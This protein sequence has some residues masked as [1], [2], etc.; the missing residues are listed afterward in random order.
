MTEHHITCADCDELLSGYFED[1]L[2]APARAS[3]EAH[4]AGCARCQRLIRDIDGIR[5]DAAALPGMVP[6]R[7][8]WQ[9]IESRIQPTVVPILL[10]RQ[11]GLSRR[12]LG[13]AAAGLIVISSSI[14][15]VATRS[16]NGTSKRPVR[17][18]Q[19]PPEVPAGTTDENGSL[20][21]GVVTQ[22]AGA[23]PARNPE[24]ARTE[25]RPAGRSTTSGRTALASAASAASPSE[26]ALA[27]EISR[28]Q[29]LLRERRS[30]L[31][32]STVKV[33][34][35][36]L[37]LIDAA[38]MQARSALERDP[39]SGFLT[40]RLDNVLQKKI[41]LLRTVALLPSRS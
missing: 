34:E 39:A 22:P 32:P 30:Q 1:E 29:Q 40:E 28:L 38:V 8:L 37:R 6:S 21:V 13:L 20:S 24:S 2:Y 7:D 9:G 31:D 3:V 18:V 5:E 27:P 17:V 15:Y 12:V 35:E 4:A 16:V 10:R 19:A 25:S 41:E 23:E 36:N 14:T 11:P 33:V 26:V